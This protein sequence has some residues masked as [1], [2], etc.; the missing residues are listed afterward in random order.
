MD[1]VTT[2]RNAVARHLDRPYT[3]MCLTDQPE[4]CRRGL[5]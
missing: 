1:C 5:C 4:R 3:M 2:L